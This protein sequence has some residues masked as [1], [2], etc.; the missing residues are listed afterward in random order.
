MRTSLLAVAFAAALV[1]APA[2]AAVILGTGAGAVQPDENLLFNNNPANGLAIIGITNQSD[3]LVTV[4]GGEPL[5][6]NGGQARVE[7]ADDRI[8][9]AFTYQGLSGQLLGFDFADTARAFT[10]AEFKVFVGHG[11]A[12]VLTLTAFT[13]QGQQVQQAFD[14][15]SSGFFYLDA[16]N[17]DLIDRFS[18]AANGSLEDVRQIRIGG[19]QE[20]SQSISA[21][22]PEPA[23][24]AMMILGFGGLG[25]AL[26]ARRAAA[27]VASA[28]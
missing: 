25:A 16:T 23:T 3:T 24:W 11:T 19:V 12:T 21:A 17:G 2:G 5:V 6:G 14:I 13:T 27:R 15:P 28:A 1:A 20:I 9:S 8:S 18:F 10:Q 7:A 4:I 26:R 22:V